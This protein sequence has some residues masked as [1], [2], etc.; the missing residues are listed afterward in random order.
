[1]RGGGS[2]GGG[3]GESV[4]CVISKCGFI[5]V[6]FGNVFTLGKCFLIFCLA[7]FFCF[8]TALCFGN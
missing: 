6:R 3:G 2:G 1:M 7:F 8:R 4:G 5:V